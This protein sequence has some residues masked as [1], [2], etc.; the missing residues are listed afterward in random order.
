MKIRPPSKLLERVGGSFSCGGRRSLAAKKA[1]GDH[2]PPAAK[3]AVST[4]DKEIYE[5]KNES[6]SFLF[7]ISSQVV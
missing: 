4:I 2:E 6:G 5:T 7:R 1:T 3:F